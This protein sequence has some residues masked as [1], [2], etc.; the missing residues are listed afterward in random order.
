MFVCHLNVVIGTDWETF[1]GFMFLLYVEKR[2]KGQALY[3]YLKKK[4]TGSLCLFK[5]IVQ[6][7]NLQAVQCVD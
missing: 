1:N 4:G 6:F 5:I 2:K 3:V 7:P